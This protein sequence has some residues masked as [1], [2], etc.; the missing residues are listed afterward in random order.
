MPPSAAKSWKSGVIENERRE[1]YYCVADLSGSAIAFSLFFIC[2]LLASSQSK[3]NYL[4]DSLFAA[5]W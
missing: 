5:Q 3:D 4:A 2:E 1:N